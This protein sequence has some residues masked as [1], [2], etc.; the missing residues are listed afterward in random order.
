MQHWSGAMGPGGQTPLDVLL[1]TLTEQE[2]AGVKAWLGGT[3]GW[4]GAPA[5]VSPKAL[6]EHHEKVESDRFRPSDDDPRAIR[7]IGVIGG[8]TAGYMT[9]LALKTKRPWLDVTLVESKEIPII[10]VGEATVSY[11]VMFLHHFLGIDSMELYR[12]VEPTWKLGIKFDWGPDPDGFMAT[13]DWHHH[14]IGAL[15]ALEAENTVNGFTVQSLMMMADRAG[16]YEIDGKYVSLMK[17]LPFAY[18]LD[19][20]RFVAFLTEL[21]EQR[22]VRHVEARLDDVV[23]GDD[24][25]VDHVRTTDGRELR[26]DFYVDCTGFRSMLLGKALDTPF[27]SYA[28]SLFTDSAVTGNLENGGHL[29]PYTTATTMN[30]G[31]CWNIPTPQSDH[32]GYVYSSS[33]LSDD[34]AHKELTERFPGIE[35]LRQVRFRSGRHDK[36]WRGN[37]MAIGNSYAFVEPLESTGLLMIALAVQTLTSVLPASWSDEQARDVVNIGLGQRWDAIRWFLAIHYKFNTRLDTEFW[38][39]VRERCDISGFQPLLALYQNGAPL[40]RRDPYILDLALGAAPTFFGLAGIDNIL[41]GQKVPARLLQRAEPIED[42]WAR[43]KAGDA[44]V[45]RALTQSRALEAFRTDPELNAQLLNDLD[46]WAGRHI[47]G[48]IGM[49]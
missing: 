37:V 35:G 45:S 4:P 48:Y 1:E 34:E 38:K 24:E 39:D 14:S 17:Y 5:G 18:H 7:S 27:H 12:K 15:G 22:G 13:F 10:G 11:M 43:R 19:N 3:P 33:A 28:G 47:A 2:S 44:L 23:L 29:K 20:A 25:W 41:L 46:S 16:V 32:L 42:W 21:A 40:T 9:A 26:Y 31:W 6:T 49:L 36:A 30:A 8:G